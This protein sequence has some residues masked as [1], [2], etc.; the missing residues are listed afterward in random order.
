MPT[1]C[2]AAETGPGPSSSAGIAIYPGASTTGT[3]LRLDGGSVGAG[4][5]YSIQV[6]PALP[7]GRYTA[8]ATQS[9]S[10]G[11]TGYSGP[12]TFRIKVHPPAVTL[13]GAASGSRVT[14]STLVFSGTAGTQLGDSSHVEVILYAGRSVRGRQI[15][16][17]SVTA[18]HGRWS[19]P[20]PRRLALGRYTVRANQ[21]DDAGH[22]GLS[23]AHS[24]LIVP[25][26]G[27][28]G[29]PVSLSHRGVASVPITCAALAGK[30]CT[31]VVL[32]L[33]VATFR[34][35]P[36][37]PA[38]P[39]RVIFAY[40][41]IPAGRTLVVRQAVASN[42]LG[43]LRRAGTVKVRVAAPLSQ[44]GGAP[45]RTLAASRLVRPAT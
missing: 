11:I 34:A 35:V 15:G 45:A 19:A 5:R 36:G 28:I 21:S 32:V 8:L 39:L 13:D 24:F 33:T 43:M 42:V 10:G 20:W 9:D 23:T 16:T 17:L 22:A 41:S 12:R 6:T 25:A 26:S 18:R 29:S 31:S 38:G 40:V 4:R 27:V 3:P 14:Q 37:G 44:S 30:P 1:L 7:D 2:G